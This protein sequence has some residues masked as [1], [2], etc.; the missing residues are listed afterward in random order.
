MFVS[1]LQTLTT[2]NVDF[3]SYTD[4]IQ[5]VLSFNAANALLSS[6]TCDTSNCILSHAIQL[7]RVALIYSI[8]EQ[9]YSTVSKNRYFVNLQYSISRLTGSRIYA[10]DP[11]PSGLTSPIGDPNHFV[12]NCSR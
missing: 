7:T 6:S 5:T 4:Y 12:M 10:G 11:T 3:H 9:H 1:P 8:Y 2:I